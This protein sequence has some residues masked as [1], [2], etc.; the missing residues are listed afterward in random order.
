MYNPFAE[1][2]NQIQNNQI[3]TN[4]PKRSNDQTFMLNAKSITVF[5]LSRRPLVP[6][7]NIADI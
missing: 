3:V 6:L 7:M 4:Q 5:N 1:Y 2:F